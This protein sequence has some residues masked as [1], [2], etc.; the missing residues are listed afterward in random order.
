M[1]V[2]HG[3]C[4]LSKQEIVRLGPVKISKATIEGAWRGRQPL[5]RTIIADAE[6]RGLALIVNAQSMAWRFE[7]KPRGVDAHTG[8][9]FPSKS[10]VLG[11]PASLSPDAAR[12]VANKHKGEA[13]SGEDP[14]EKKKAKLAEDARKRAG[15]LKR[16]LELYAEALPKRPKMRGGEGL[17]SPKAVAEELMHTKAAIA[18]MSA[19]DKPAGEVAGTD[20]KRMLDGQQSKVATARHRYGALSRF[21]DWAVEEQHVATNPCGQVVKR[22][23]PRP[24]KSRRVHHKPSQLGQLWGAIRTAEGL[25]QVHRDL[26]HFLITMPCRR[27]EATRMLWEDVDLDRS[28]WAL[29]GTQTKNGDPHTFYL[30]ALSLDILKRRY[31][32]MGHPT[33]GLVF[34]APRSGKAIDTFGKIKMAIDEALNVKLDWRFH[35]HRRSFVTALAE[36]GFHEAVL[37]A[38]LNHRQSATRSGVLGTYQHA[39]RL[40]EQAAAMKK[41]CEILSAETGS[42]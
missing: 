4:T 9:R 1:S 27:G 38:I 11:N 18:G 8:K 37:D 25:Q 41:W 7:Y 5:R 40:P 31:A 6:C 15:T 36:A 23:R 22:L 10:I 13:K 39:L 16:L 34:P 17:L 14:A 35:D 21:Y 30:H 29:S 20:V 28:V 32:E 26:L 24:P 42:G 33:S 3:E 19:M 12:D 2:L